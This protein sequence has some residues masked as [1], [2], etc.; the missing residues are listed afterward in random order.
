MRLSGSWTLLAEEGEAGRRRGMAWGCKW[1]A[2]PA[3]QVEHGPTCA[4]CS[5]PT[6]YLH[7]VV[8]LC[9]FRWVV[10]GRASGAATA[11]AWV[12]LSS[13]KGKGVR[14]GSQQ[15]THASCG[16]ESNKALRGISDRYHTTGRD[17]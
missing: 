1:A 7:R 5:S 9:G 10:C 3:E 14:G 2:D 4:A 15:S 12:F 17:A 6:K 16:Y 11:L 8:G 13:R